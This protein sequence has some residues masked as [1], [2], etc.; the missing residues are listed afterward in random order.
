MTL[1]MLE[2]CERGGIGMEGIRKQQNKKI[3]PKLD[4]VYEQAGS[5]LETLLIS[6]IRQPSRIKGIDP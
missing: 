1:S 4:Y 5:V 6:S 2:A 3:C